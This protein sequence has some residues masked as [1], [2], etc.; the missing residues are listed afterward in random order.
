MAGDNKKRKKT[1]LT[2]KVIVGAIVIIFCIAKYGDYKNNSLENEVRVYCD[3]HLIGKMGEGIKQDAKSKNYKI[4]EYEL[5]NIHRIMLIKSF[6]VFSRHICYIE[7]KN[8][9]IVKADYGHVD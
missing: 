4:N 6:M 5:N 2:F 3:K 7:L 8:G 1:S 9:I